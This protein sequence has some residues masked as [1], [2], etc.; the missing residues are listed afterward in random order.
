M[1]TNRLFLDATSPLND[2]EGCALL[3]NW[4]R[5][6]PLAPTLVWSVSLS[7]LC[8][9]FG[10]SAFLWQSEVP[11]GFS[12]VVARVRSP[13]SGE[14][15]PYECLAKWILYLTTFNVIFPVLGGVSRGEL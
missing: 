7:C 5:F 10:G 12:V 3:A 13:T 15:W 4:G 2:D 8:S 14:W 11:N 6:M 9:S 1:P